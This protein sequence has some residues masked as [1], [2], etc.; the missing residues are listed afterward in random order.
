M[1]ESETEIKRWTAKRKT[2]V[3]LDI[4]KGKTTVANEI[5]RRVGPDRIVT[6]NQDRYYYNLAH[7][8]EAQ[9]IQKTADEVGKADYDWDCE[10]KDTN[11]QVVCVTSN[12]YQLRSIKP[13]SAQ[14]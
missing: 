12:R 8:D 7:L 9:R 14:S 13:P 6:I 4:L 3:V 10:L 2:Q 1:S 11:G 5:L